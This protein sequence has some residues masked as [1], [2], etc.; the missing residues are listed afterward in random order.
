MAQ[1]MPDWSELQPELLA[2]IARRLNLIE[3]YSIFR[4]VC[5][6]WHSAATKN[7]FNSDLPRVPWLM[8]AEEDGSSSCR[9]FFSLYNGMILKKRI[10]KA[11]RKLCMESLGWL[12]T[13]GE[14]EGEVSLLHPFSG[15]QIELPHQNS[16]AD[17]SGR[18]TGNQC[19]F[20]K[21][22][23]LSASPS[24]TSDYILMV[25]DGGYI[26]FWKRGDLRWNKI[27]LDLGTRSPRFAR[28][29]DL[30]YFNGYFYS[31][32]CL[33][34]IIVYD[35]A[36]PQYPR[37]LLVAQIPFGHRGFVGEL[38]ILESL[39]SLFVVSR[40]GVHLRY[41]RDGTT[42]FRVFQVDLASGKG[43]ETRELGDR[44]FFVGYN[45]SISVQASQFPGI[46]PNHIYFTDHYLGSYQTF[47]EGGGL[48]MGVFNLADGSIQPHY[49]G[50][51]LSRISPPT[52]V[53]PTLY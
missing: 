14:D 4:T 32:D 10:P 16:T 53:T 47:E 31:V 46:K 49:N 23:V 42:D 27:I 24:H 41:F 30:V 28:G 2:L 21:K 29:R 37:S 7:N 11:S 17:Y 8:L 18:R 50:V 39:E 33:G 25:I 44:A 1:N 34:R 45:A 12:I 22:A 52:W 20:F 48:D 40:K 36:G 38:Y 6:S 43:T 13:V 9:K 3:D 26:K 19:T 51:S 15:V 35:V 5:K